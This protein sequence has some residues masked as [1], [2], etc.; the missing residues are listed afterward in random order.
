MKQINDVTAPDPADLFSMDL[1]YNNPT[2]SGGTA[3]FNGNIS[4][5][6]WKSAGLDK[7]SFG[8]YYDT[9][10]RLKEARYFNAVK[11]TNNGRFNEV[12]GGG[13][14]T[15]LKNIRLRAK[16]TRTLWFPE[17]PLAQ[18]VRFQNFNL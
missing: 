3:Q 14:K 8:D 5:I 12:I 11:T 13:L 1:R 15:H 16:P 10:N 2:A 7:Q 4:E 6:V 17:G 18:S 9:L